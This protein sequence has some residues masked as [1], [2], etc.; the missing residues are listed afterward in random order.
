[1]IELKVKAWSFN[2]SKIIHT[3]NHCW[4]HPNLEIKD[5][6]HIAIKDI[7]IIIIKTLTSIKT[8]TTKTKSTT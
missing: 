6:S 3:Y 4:V 2:N 5:Y 1:M 8:Q 7:I